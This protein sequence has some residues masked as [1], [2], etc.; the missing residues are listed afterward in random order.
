MAR[1][2]DMMAL[3]PG[4]RR[5]ARAAAGSTREGD[6]HVAAALRRLAGEPPLGSAPDELKAAAY[7]AFHR[8]WDG[9][10]PGALAPV[11]GAERRL[12]DLPRLPREALLL[13]ALEGFSTNEAAKILGREA[14]EIE[15]ALGQAHAA[16]EAQLATR[17]LLVEDE[18]VIALDLSATLIGLGHDVAAIADT[19]D[20]AVAAARDMRPGLVVADV[21]LADGSSGVEAV[22]EIQRE[23]N[24]PAVFVTAYPERVVD[25]VGSAFVSKPF[26]A[27]A[28]RAAVERA[29]FFA[30]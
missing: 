29:L 7:A 4:L 30:D 1:F 15:A 26:L 16:I 17:I 11:S 22:R 21:A 28:V 14:A 10:A 9:D 6:R 18:A 13:S 2:G 23:R 3:L 25:G 12:R 5:Y 24:V 27:S 19:A 8:S 20:K